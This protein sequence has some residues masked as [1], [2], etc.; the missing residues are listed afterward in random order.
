W[1][2]TSSS[3]NISPEFPFHMKKMSLIR[4][5]ESSHSYIPISEDR[6]SRPLQGLR[7]FVSSRNGLKA[8]STPQRENLEIMKTIGSQ[9]KRSSR[10]LGLSHYSRSDSAPQLRYTPIDQT[11]SPGSPVSLKCSAQGSPSPVITWTRDRQPLL[12]THRTTVGSFLTQ[13]GDV[14]SH[15]NLTD[16]TV[17]DGGAYTCTAHNALGSSSHSAR[18]NVYGPPF[19]RAMPNVTAIAGENVHLFCPAG[20][21][22]AP[23]ITWRRN[24]QGLPSDPRQEKLNNG[25]LI[26]RNAGHTDVGRYSCV[27]SNSQ[28]QTAASHTF[29]QILSKKM[30]KKLHF[31]K[32]MIC[33]WFQFQSLLTLR[34]YSYRDNKL[35]FMTRNSREIS[36]FS[37]YISDQKLSLKI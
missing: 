32:D 21:F 6:Q 10:D 28:G 30:M 11:V 29:L 36:S 8:T 15:V 18:I 20:G 9:L 3:R 23:A 27:V 12:P 31:S 13:L 35:L 33:L 4:R 17:R 25:T 26:I 7:Y 37:Q 24:R 14:V 22:P 34:G 19:V 16:I 2:L 5:E 1:R